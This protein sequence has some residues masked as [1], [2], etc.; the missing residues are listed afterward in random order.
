MIPKIIHQVWIGPNPI[1]KHCEEFSNQM[2][3][4][5]PSWKHILWDNSSM[6]QEIFK[7]D[8]IISEWK[9]LLGS[10][11]YAPTII[12]ERIRFLVLHEYGGI[13]A[14]IDAAPIRSFDHLMKEVKL[15]TEFFGGIKKR[16]D[17][18]A[19]ESIIDCALVGSSP[20]SL[21]SKKCLEI[22]E[23]HVNDFRPSYCILFSHE[24]LELQKRFP[25]KIQSF[26]KEYF[27]DNKKTSKTIVLHDIND[28]RLWSWRKGRPIT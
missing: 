25:S 28:T 23:K 6:E 8:P 17:P 21:A 9:K 1:P 10:R 15:E 19:S 5:N 11:I 27:Y 12:A 4:M 26:D 22:L 13:Y 3:K 20:K 16:Q 24:L 7:K 2:K 18:G 14:D